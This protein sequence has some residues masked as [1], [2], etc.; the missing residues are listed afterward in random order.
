MRL[1]VSGFRGNENC[2]LKLD[3]V[4]YPTRYS[5]LVTRHWSI[6]WHRKLRPIK[7]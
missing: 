4:S 3:H 2:N 7:A 5:S 1:Q 6:A